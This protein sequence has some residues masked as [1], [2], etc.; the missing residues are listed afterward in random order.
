MPPAPPPEPWQLGICA[1]DL[2]A[3]FLTQQGWEV[4]ARRWRG[5]GGE[6]DL[7]VRLEGRLRVVE[8][9][10]RQPEDPVGL[11]CVDARKLAHLERAAEAFLQEYI[12]PLT[13]VCLLVALVEPQGDHARVQLFDNPT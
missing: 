3:R 12:G 2:V 1:E 9:K 5:G 8:V 4:L 11:E 10:L 6:L 13:E 7:V